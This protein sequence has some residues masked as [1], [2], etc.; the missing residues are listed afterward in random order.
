MLLRVMTLPLQ[1]GIF[2][3]NITAR[4]KSFLTSLNNARLHCKLRDLATISRLVGMVNGSFFS[5]IQMQSAEA[6][7]DNLPRQFLNGLLYICK[8]NLQYSLY[9]IEG[10]DSQ[11]RP[12]EIC[13]Q[14]L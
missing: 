4:D 2:A 10:R 6:V 1:Q 3:N 14:F 13:Y 12:L 5:S 8:M 7:G 11:I 9:K